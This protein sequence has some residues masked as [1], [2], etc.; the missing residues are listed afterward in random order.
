MGVPQISQPYPYSP[1]FDFSKGMTIEAW[2]NPTEVQG[3]W[4][5]IVQKDED[6]YFLTA[7]SDAGVLQSAGG[8][9]FGGELDSVKLPQPI[10][11]GVWTHLA[12][13]YDAGTLALYVNGEPATVRQRWSS[14]R[15]S[16]GSVGTVD[17]FVEGVSR[18]ADLRTQLIQGAPLRLTLEADSWHDGLA[19][20]VRIRDQRQREVFFVGI[21]SENIV[22]RSRVVAARLG[23]YVPASRFQAAWFRQDP[24]RSRTIAISRKQRSYCLGVVA[25]G[26]CGF[27]P[28]VASGWAFLIDSASVSPRLEDL[29][30]LVWLGVMSFAAGFCT[31]GRRTSYAAVVVLALVVLLLP[32]IAGLPT[33]PGTVAFGGFAAL[34]T[35]WCCRIALRR[36]ALRVS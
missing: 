2:V 19:P 11:V 15:V 4:G 28:S 32:V 21:E 6:A 18:S 3:N 14:V 30:D 35:G 22:L 24:D 8:G 17:I 27:G 20:L 31:Y 23:L 10:P 13:T 34:S 33:V 7:G 5:N 16:K 25:D 26:R 9:S 36:A 29:F 1:D 12:I